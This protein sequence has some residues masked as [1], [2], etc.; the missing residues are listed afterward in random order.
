MTKQYTDTRTYAEV[1]AGVKKGESVIDKEA[2]NSNANQ[3]AAGSRDSIDTVVLLEELGSVLDA[4]RSG[5]VTDSNQ[6]SIDDEAM[7]NLIRETF[8]YERR[9]G[10]QFETVKEEGEEGEE[11]DPDY[12]SDN[13]VFE[14]NQA[15]AAA[16]AQGIL[17]YQKNRPAR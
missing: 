11:I 2:R 5:S 13:D 16:R 15:T 3:D 12:E 7:H 17:P 14:P 6:S 8:P 10:S 9:R 4:S 1:A